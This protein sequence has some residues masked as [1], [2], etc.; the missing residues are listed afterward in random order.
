[1]WS[2]PPKG[3]TGTLWRGSGRA[4]GRRLWPPSR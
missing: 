1:M 4:S 2:P 3:R